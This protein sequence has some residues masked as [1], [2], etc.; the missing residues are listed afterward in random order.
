MDQVIMKI[1]TKVV[2]AALLLSAIAVAAQAQLVERKALSI[3]GAH[4]VIAGAVAYA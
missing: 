2:T 1:L 4:K 3:E